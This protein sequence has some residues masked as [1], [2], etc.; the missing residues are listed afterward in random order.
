MEWR[1]L[2]VEELR[3]WK[4]VRVVRVVW[5]GSSKVSVGYTRDLAECL[6]FAPAGTG[7]SSAGPFWVA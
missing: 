5:A 2:E 3:V 6:Y 7:A 1:G 4:V